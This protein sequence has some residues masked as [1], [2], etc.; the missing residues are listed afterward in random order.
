VKNPRN[1]LAVLALAA[2]FGAGPAA[3]VVGADPA[4]D[5]HL[6]DLQTLV[7]TDLQVQM[8]G[9]KKLLRLTNTVANLGAGRLEIRPQNSAGSETTVAFQRVYTHD[10]TGKKWS[11]A[12]EKEIGTFVFHPAHNHWHLEGFARYDLLNRN[13]KVVR[14]SRKVSFCLVDSTAVDPSLPHAAD[15]RRY[16]TCSKNAV[17]GISVGWGDIYLSSLAGQSINIT[18][19]P[20]GRYRLRSTADPFNRI[21]ETN[22][23]NNGSVVRFRLRGR[24]IIVL[25]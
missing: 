3:G 19:L 16:T 22:N 13:G 24:R 17:Q 11:L 2:A 6:P 4:G 21:R 10:G 8:I 9:S 23:A 25:D 5:P 20:N 15:A 18:G 7:P 1:L 12:Y 14:S